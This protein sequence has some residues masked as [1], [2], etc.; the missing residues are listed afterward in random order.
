MIK[1][2]RGEDE[3]RAD[4]YGQHAREGF[5]NQFQYHARRK[6]MK[7]LEYILLKNK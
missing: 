4:E 1:T 6:K 7:L 3:T 5:R 2:Q